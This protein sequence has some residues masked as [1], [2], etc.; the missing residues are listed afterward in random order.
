MDF[1]D[2]FDITDMDHLRAYKHLMNVG[3]WPEGFI[4]DNVEMSMGWSIGIA[5]TMANAYINLKLG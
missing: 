1:I 2:W 4:P 3:S 5:G